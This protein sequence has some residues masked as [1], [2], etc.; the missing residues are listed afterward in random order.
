MRAIRAAVVTV[1]LPVALVLGGCTSQGSDDA[2]ATPGASGTV[3]TV[4]AEPSPGE[5]PSPGQ[6]RSPS[7]SPT[8]TTPT[9]TGS[10]APA[11]GET[12][13]R[14]TRSG[15]F[16]GRTSSLIIKGDGSFTRFDAKAKQTGTGRL[17]AAELTALRTALREADFAHL[18][19]VATSG[20]TVFDGFTYAFVHGGYEVTTADGSIPPGLTAVLGALPPFE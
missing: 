18:P 11:P 8:P 13:L 17:S 6:T 19:R 9:P 2:P 12:L 20:G 10:Q 1:A 7:P 16:A 4:S 15:G 3:P 14:V 5:T